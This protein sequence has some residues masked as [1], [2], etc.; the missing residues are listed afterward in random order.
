M[1]YVLCFM[2]HL[3]DK[4]D[5]GSSWEKVIAEIVRIREGMLR[6]W[7][8]PSIICL[9]M[10]HGFM[11][12]RV[13]LWKYTLAYLFGPQLYVCIICMSI[14]HCMCVNLICS[15][16]AVKLV[17]NNRFNIYFCLLKAHEVNWLSCI[18]CCVLITL[19]VFI[20]LLIWI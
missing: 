12:C 17:F 1:A 19:F 11:F 15:L 20:V 3:C 5:Q 6:L 10:A 16:K 8:R 2:W 9:Q 13:L 18:F 7:E 4:N 14:C